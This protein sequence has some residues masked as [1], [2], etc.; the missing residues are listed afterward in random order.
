MF[1]KSICPQLASSGVDGGYKIMPHWR[2]NSEA[3]E[4]DSGHENDDSDDEDFVPLNIIHSSSDA[5]S[6][7]SYIRGK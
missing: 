3:T 6:N 2:G 1:P 7:D 5:E 4:D